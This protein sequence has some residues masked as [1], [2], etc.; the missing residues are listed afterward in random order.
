MLN[1]E[2]KEELDAY[3]D[4][5]TVLVE[6]SIGRPHEVYRITTEHV[7]GEIVVMI[8]MGDKVEPN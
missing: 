4:H 1:G 7:N 8:V 2:A 5:L 6:D 3:G